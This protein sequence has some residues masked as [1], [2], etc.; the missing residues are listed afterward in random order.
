MK[1]H[2]FR[3]LF[4]LIAALAFGP[5]SVGAQEPGKSPN[6]SGAE[7]DFHLY[8]LI[9]QSNM[10]GRGNVDDESKTAHPRVL[11]LNKAKE[12]VPATDPMHFDKPAA[13][14]GPGLAF[15]KL[16]AEQNP[17]VRIGLIPCA[18][19]GSAIRAW[20]PGAEDKATKT[21]P[22]DDMLERAK[23]ALKTGE[24]KGILW[25]QGESDL[26]NPGYGK[27][28]TELVE[29]LR[30]DL[31]APNVPFIASELSPLNPKTA[32]AVAEFNKIVHGLNFPGYA[33]ISGEGLED[34]GDKLHYNTASART[35]GKRYAE[36]MNA[37]QSGAQK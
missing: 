37:I 36:K 10:A 19:G 30:K 4:T 32:D 18:V 31:A 7:P 6:A 34:R 24:L 11:M 23:A 12:W 9:G 22:Y 15:G 21:H 13:A 35:L 17:K 27:D 14:V 33:W 5:L 28:L 29:R 8:L 2:L 16:M 20:M 3:T 26:K 1:H 25:H